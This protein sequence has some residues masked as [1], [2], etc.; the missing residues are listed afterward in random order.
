MAALGERCLAESFRGRLSGI[1]FSYG[2][3]RHLVVNGTGTV[4]VL[5]DCR[6]FFF[7][8]GGKDIEHFC[9]GADQRMA[10][11]GEYIAVARSP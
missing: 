2:A 3:S 4:R 5:S 8:V 10:A 6:R 11:L 7:L 1:G 9:G